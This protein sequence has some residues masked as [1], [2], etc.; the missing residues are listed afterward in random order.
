ML[1]VGRVGSRWRVCEVLAVVKR[2]VVNA[3]DRIVEVNASRG[4]V[5]HNV[6]RI[7]EGRF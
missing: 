2:I 3:V 4:I 6:H 1:V 5:V 7:E